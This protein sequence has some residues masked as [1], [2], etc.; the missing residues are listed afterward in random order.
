MLATCGKSDINFV[1]FIDRLIDTGDNVSVLL[2]VVGSGVYG[3]TQLHDVVYIVCWR[4]S[5]ILRFNATTHQRLTDIDVE[6]LRNP[7]DIAACE[8]TSHV[9][10][11]GYECVW[12]VS[13]DCEDMKRWWRRKTRWWKPSDTLRPW[14]LSVTSSRVLV[15]SRDTNQLMQLNE[16][17]EELRR[18][19]LPEYMRPWHAVESPSATFIVSHE[20]TELKQW[21]VSKVNTEGQVLRQF[22]GP[23]LSP[24]SLT[25][26]IAVDSRGN[27]FVA[28]SGNRRILLL[29]AQLA[30]RRVIIDKHQL[31]D[32]PPYRLCYNEQSGQLMVALGGGVAV[33]DVLKR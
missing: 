5:T 29:D 3:V 18:V 32:L 19:Q 4:S 14:T 6:D 22:S 27:I 11:A 30:L 7:W 10:V 31:N 12:R 21:Q 8:Q 1:M 17:G 23:R 25:P 2:C 24:L 20:N 16:A 33:F 15:T 9:Y 28:D 26:H 13:S